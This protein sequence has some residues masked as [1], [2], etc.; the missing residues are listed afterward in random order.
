MRN[1]VE[2]IRRILSERVMLLDGAMGSMIQRYGLKEEDFR[3]E[4]FADHDKPLK[5]DNDVLVLTRP[6]VIGDIH[7]QYL[8]AGADII[9]TCSFNSTRVSQADYGMGE[10]VYDFNVGAA[11]VAKAMAEKYTTAEWPR[12]VAGSI[13]PTGKTASL[14]PDVNDPG[15]REITFDELKEAYGEQVRGLLDGGVD[16]LL[17]ETVFDGLNAKAA[18]TAIEEELARRGEERFPVMVSATIADKSGR[19]LSGQTVEAF[20]NSVSH[21]ELLTF[22]LNCSFGAREMKP[23][24]TEIG[25]KSQFLVSAYPNAGL[26]NAEGQYDETPEIMADNVDSLLKEGVVNIIGGC[27][28][29]TPAHIAAMRERIDRAMLH[30][31]AEARHTMNLSGLDSLTI[32][33]P[34]SGE[35][36]RF[37]K[38]GERANVAGSRKFLRLISEKKYD[39]ALSIARAEAEAGADVIDVNM[40]DGMLDAVEEMKTFLNLLQSEPDVARLPVMIDSSK[41][42]VIEAGLKCVQGKAIVNSISLKKGEEEFLREAAYIKSMGA[43]TVVMAFDEE[44]QATTFERRTAVCQRAY[45][46]LTEKIGFEPADIIFDPNVLAIATGMAEHNDYAVDFIKTVRWIKKNLPYAKVSGGISNL[47]FSFRGNTHVREA[48]HSVFLHYAI[49][50]GM[51]MGI[52]NPQ[53]MIAYEDIEPELIEPLEDLV[54]NR[55]EDATDRMIDLAEKYKTVKTTAKATEADNWR[56]GSVEERLMTALVKGTT[57]Y[58]EGDIAEARGKYP[59]AIDI[60]EKPLMDGMNKVGELFGAGAMFLPQVVKTARV[61][62]RAVEILQ[63]AIEEEKAAAGQAVTSAG[64]VIMATVKGDVHDIGK[65]IVSVVL[66][67]NNFDIVDLGVMVETEKIVD[68]VVEHK[69]DAVGLSGL[70]TPSLD[71]MIAVVRAL[72]ARGITVPV[73]IGGA[74]TSAVHTAV[75]IA[76]EYS[77]TVVY[78]KDASRNAYVLNALLTTNGK[79]AEEVKAEQAKLREEY[80][81]EKGEGEKEGEKGEEKDVKGKKEEKGEEKGER[82]EKGREWRIVKPRKMGVTEIREVSI[83]TVEPYIN[84]KMFLYAWKIVAPLTDVDEVEDEASAEEWKK[85]QTADK[86]VVDAAAKLLVE[87]RKALRKMSEE[88]V[89]RLHGVVGLFAANHT[90][91]DRVSIYKDEKREEEIATMAFGRQQSGEKLSLADYIAEKPTGDYIG[92]FAATSGDGLKEVTDR[93]RGEGDDYTAIMYSF[94]ADRLVEALSEWMHWKVRT[95]IWGYDEWE[96]ADAKKMRSGDFK[97]IRPAIGYPIAPDHGLKTKLFDAMQVSERIPMTLTESLMMVPLSSVCGL[98]VAQEWAKYFNVQ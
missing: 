27:C 37:Y 24:L 59:R 38:V 52:V 21:V 61:M 42:E 72:E 62:K 93:L 83:E 84:W 5:G 75:K 68:A 11:K 7:R 34:A 57:D 47:S 43:A 77:G 17:V 32:D 54:L 40:D 71:E 60:I 39:E 30:K 58:L 45:K 15:K 88:K 90:G 96:V 31:P 41:W 2:E 20:L 79:F 14:S 94:L 13:G 25:G 9:E 16:I 35:G 53:A 81:R 28:G 36:H 76:P 63:P 44:G 74:T 55:R 87:G 70:I 89:T 6:D 65:N 18:L 98:Y 51:D 92:M 22:G 91:E 97:G 33:N 80:W 67:C 46:L 48:I 3:G 49:A 10:H 19:I 12:F 50:E 23:Y 8:E 85:K 82:K 64:K 73:M 66:A 4:L 69:A 29:T 26:P 95:E 86:T 1:R 56:Q 78:V